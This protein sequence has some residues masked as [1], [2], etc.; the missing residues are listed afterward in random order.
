MGRFCTN[1]VEHLKEGAKYY[2]S[3]Y[4]DGYDGGDDF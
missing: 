4:Y 3:D 2:D 1:C